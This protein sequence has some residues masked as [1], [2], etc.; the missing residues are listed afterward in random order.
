MKACVVHG[1]KTAADCMACA[2]VAAH[3][4]RSLE[5]RHATARAAGGHPISSDND[6]WRKLVDLARVTEEL[7]MHEMLLF[8]EIPKPERPWRA[9]MIPPHCVALPARLA[10]DI[11]CTL[12]Q[13][14]LVAAQLADLGASDHADAITRARLLDKIQRAADL[15]A[16]SLRDRRHLR[17]V[18]PEPEQA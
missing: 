16:R 4:R 7:E 13:L 12:T 15:V 1:L 17:L 8:A 10:L 5:D 18:D 14:E 11:E 9:R 6:A 3:R 2:A